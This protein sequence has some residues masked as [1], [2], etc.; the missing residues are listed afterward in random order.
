MEEVPLEEVP[1]EQPKKKRTPKKQKPQ[2]APVEEEPV[3]AQQPAASLWGGGV[4]S[5]WSA[6]PSIVNLASAAK[7]AVQKNADA[8]AAQV[9][10]YQ[11]QKLEE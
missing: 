2:P 9:A 7:E 11:A 8:A 10:Q 6:A 3:E 1:L 4:S 5:F